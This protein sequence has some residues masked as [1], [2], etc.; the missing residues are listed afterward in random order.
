MEVGPGKEQTE[1]KNSN[2]L[3]CFSTPADMFRYVQTVHDYKRLNQVTNTYVP[4]L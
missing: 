4:R 1:E 2:S 3:K